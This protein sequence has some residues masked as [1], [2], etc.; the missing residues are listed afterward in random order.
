VRHPLYLGWFFAF[1]ATPTMT[2]AHLVFAVMTTGY[3][4]VAIQ[5]EERNLVDEHGEKY[6]AYRRITPMLVPFSKSRR[7]RPVDAT[8]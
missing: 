1:W 8:A 3:I 6:I 5:L 2:M 7:P 4:L